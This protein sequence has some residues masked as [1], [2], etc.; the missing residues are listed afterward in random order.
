MR[1]EKAARKQRHSVLPSSEKRHL[2]KIS[3]A[4]P[5]SQP[6]ISEELQKPDLAKLRGLIET[7]REKYSPKKAAPNHRESGVEGGSVRPRVSSPVSRSVR[8]KL[9]DDDAEI[10]ALERALGVRGKKTLPKAFRDDGLDVFLDGLNDFN[11]EE[12]P[13]RKKQ[14]LILEER[15]WLQEKRQETRPKT[16][17][18]ANRNERAYKESLN[19]EELLSKGNQ[20]LEEDFS[21]QASEGTEEGSDGFEEDL[22]ASSRAATRENPYIAP[23][24]ATQAAK[25]LPPSL[26]TP[27]SEGN[28]LD[29]LRR[30]I[31]GTLNRLSEA[32]LL[33]IV[34]DIENL[35]RN[36]P[37]R[38]I[39]SLLI[40]R[41]Y[42]LISDPSPLQDTFMILHG[43]FVAAIYKIVG[44]EFGADMIQ[45]F[46]EEYDSVYAQKSLGDISGKKLSNLIGFLAELYTFQVVSNSIVYDFVRFFINDLSEY[47]VELLLRLTRS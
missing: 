24:Q 19:D 4:L 41:L 43:G 27:S 28:N 45:R 18:L 11:L 40:E 30:Q 21:S 12:G 35:Y 32:K 33:S 3:V 1:V 22:A 7:K 31:Q 39:S 13:A 20:S 14:R 38:E 47:T 16:N 44:T 29:Q 5:R 34:S 8:D 26:R 23:Q 46:V 36:Y 25:Y 15:S 17:L 42:M 6:G 37:R 2:N 9:A 10:E